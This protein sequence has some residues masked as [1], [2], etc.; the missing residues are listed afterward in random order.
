MEDIRKV[1]I[2]LSHS[3]IWRVDVGGIPDVTEH[4]TVAQLSQCNFAPIGMSRLRAYEGQGTG[5]VKCHIRSLQAM[6]KC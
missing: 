4:F 3:P 1:K 6:R 5:C 2:K